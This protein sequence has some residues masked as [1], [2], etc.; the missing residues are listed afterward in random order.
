[1]ACST[2]YHVGKQKFVVW[3]D[4][5]SGLIFLNAKAICISACINFKATYVMVEIL[6]LHSSFHAVSVLPCTAK[7]PSAP[8]YS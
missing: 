5:M 2:F 6:L 7:F 8:L 3:L 1:M 4:L